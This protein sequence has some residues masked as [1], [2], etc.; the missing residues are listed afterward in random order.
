MI[1]EN[2]PRLFTGPRIISPITS[3]E[4]GVTGRVEGRGL[5]EAEL[6]DAPPDF[7]KGAEATSKDCRMPG[8]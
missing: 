4:V 8:S 1:W 6:E 7:D 5:R 2:Y 3:L